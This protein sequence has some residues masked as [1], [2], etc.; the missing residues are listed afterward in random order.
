[1]ALRANYH[2]N[3]DLNY[4]RNNVTLPNGS[5]ASNLIGTRFLYALTSKMFFNAFLQ[6][7]TDT[8]RSAR[9]SA[10]TSSTTRSVTSSSCTPIPATPS[11]AGSWIGRSSSSSR[12]CSASSPKYGQ[13]SQ[14]VDSFLSRVQ[15]WTWDLVQRERVCP[16][17][18]CCSIIRLHLFHQESACASPRDR[19]SARPAP[20]SDTYGGGTCRS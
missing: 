2:L 4:T 18:T 11:Q 6:Y 8:D 5:F 7:N 15:S 1:M 17:P 19:R 3:I 10:S 12:S 20:W 14:P 16:R 13:C 9:T